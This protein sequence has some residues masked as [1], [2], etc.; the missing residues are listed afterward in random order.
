[1]AEPQEEEEV[2]IEVVPVPSFTCGLPGLKHSTNYS[3]R[4][5]C[6][7]E[8]GSSSFTNWVY[9]QTLGLGK[10]IAD[11]C[12][13]TAEHFPIIYIPMIKLGL[14]CRYLNLQTGAMLT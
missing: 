11:N 1:M 12:I 14:I 10:N 6:T 3:A 13:E 7:N 9:F 2:S 5:Q 4:V 8:I